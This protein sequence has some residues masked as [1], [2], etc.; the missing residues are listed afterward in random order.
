MASDPQK[1]PVRIRT[2]IRTTDGGERLEAD[3]LEG[4]RKK[5]LPNSGCMKKGETRNPNGR[6]KGAKG[7][8][9]LVK[10]LLLEKTTVR[11][12]GRARRVTLYHALLLKEVQLAI[13]GDWRARK[14]V[15][16]LGRWALPEDNP[17]AGKPAAQ[18]ASAVDEAVIA[19]FESEV[20]ARDESEGEDD[21]PR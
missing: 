21:E 7:T 5:R 20:R 4:P 10:K 15:L 9:A 2:R 12:S 18:D 13:A 8:K 19:W 16:E 14:T 1:P 6:P 17:L 3:R 11:E